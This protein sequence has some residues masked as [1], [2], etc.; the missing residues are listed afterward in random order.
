MGRVDALIWLLEV[1]RKWNC[2]SIDF[3]RLNLRNNGH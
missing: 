2:I 3:E 1:K